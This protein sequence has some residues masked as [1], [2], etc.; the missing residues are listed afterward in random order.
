MLAVLVLSSVAMLSIFTPLMRSAF[1]TQAQEDLRHRSDLLTRAITASV[2]D[3]GQLTE[4]VAVSF[5]HDLP[6]QLIDIQIRTNA[7]S[8]LLDA[9]HGSGSRGDAFDSGALSSP[10]DGVSEFKVRQPVTNENGDLFGTAEFAWNIGPA[11]AA[12][13]QLVRTAWLMVGITIALGSILIAYVIHQ[14]VARPIRQ[15]VEAMQD[16]TDDRHDV[17]LPETE[18]AE[19]KAMNRTLT[20]FRVT[21]LERI[22]YARR[23]AEAEARAAQLEAERRAAEAR[24]RAASSAEEA[25]YRASTEAAREAEEALIADLTRVLGRA[26]NGDFSVR[27]KPAPNGGGA[28]VPNLVNALLERVEIGIDDISVVLSR[29]AE[30]DVRARM[31]GEHKGAFARLQDDV[32]AAATQL[33]EALAEVFRRAT[34][35]LGDSS[36]LM[37]A[38]TDLSDRTERT[39]RTVAETTKALDGMARTIKQ[40]AHLASGA[41]TSASEAEGDARQSD[42]VVRDAI[43]AMEQ[44]RDF[45]ERISATL[46]IID[47]IAFQTNLLALNA[48]VEA[49]RAGNAGQGFAVVA[50]EI[51]ALA[52]RVAISAHEIGDLVHESSARIEDGVSR[53]DRT[54]ETLEA[55]GR[56]IRTIGGQ[57][58]EIADAASGQAVSASN[59][60]EAMVEIDHATQ[61]NAAMFE[62]TA[63]ANKSLK[64]AASHMLGL[65]SKFRTSLRQSDADW[66][67]P[68]EGVQTGRQMVPPSA[69]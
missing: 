11:R 39:A 57:I 30:G 66:A 61:Q 40:T 47:D 65:V 36:D 12:V 64:A 69:P 27:M 58:D 20:L 53:V 14:T 22:A 28:D 42:A 60:N 21:L 51:R 32:N 37:V 45:S 35:V 67:G 10:S 29:L 62:E 34:D 8:P 15:T 43:T 4:K 16:L 54:G 48:G 9:G 56:R 17:P 50:S 5:A 2:V 6:P 24:E 59:M 46:A 23:S 68:A 7:G 63:A 44:I 13:D 1:I 49:A 52:R 55:L 19:L 26:S 31:E 25:R 3:E 38:A 41:R 33:D 18:I